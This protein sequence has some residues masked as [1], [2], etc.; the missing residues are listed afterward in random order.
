MSL[1]DTIGIWGKQ[2]KVA[3]TGYGSCQFIIRDTG[4]GM[5]PESQQHIFELFSRM[6]KTFDWQLKLDKSFQKD[7][8]K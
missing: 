5:K 2:L 4:M 3:L 7:K 6:E 1:G 8:I